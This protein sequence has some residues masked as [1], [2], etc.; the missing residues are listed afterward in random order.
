MLKDGFTSLSLG[1]EIS[2]FLG[3]IYYGGRNM[4]SFREIIEAHSRE[5][6]TSIILALDL[7]LPDRKAQLEKSMSILESVHDSI[8]AVKLNRQ[9][10]LPL[11]L[12]SGA[13]KIVARAQD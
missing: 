13:D 1:S 6:E 8:C 9:I 10:V 3:L 4:R 12:Y 2:E 11:G 5:K 7:F